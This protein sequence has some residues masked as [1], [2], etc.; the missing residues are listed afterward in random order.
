MDQSAR[1]FLRGTVR[2]NLRCAPCIG[3]KS[4]RAQ[5]RILASKRKP[6]ARKTGWTARS[7]EN[8]KLRM[9]SKSHEA[10]DLNPSST[11]R[12]VFPKQ[13]IPGRGTKSSPARQGHRG[14][15]VQPEDLPRCWLKCRHV[16]GA[17]FS[18]SKIIPQNRVSLP[19][20]RGCEETVNLG[21][22]TRIGVQAGPAF[23]QSRDHLE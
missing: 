22:L 15:R 18:F 6:Q 14:L 7:S 11:F 19:L 1:I 4:T 13:K 21:L 17:F 16:P 23:L 2:Q 12:V 10:R 20:G 3:S 9:A 5:T 8:T